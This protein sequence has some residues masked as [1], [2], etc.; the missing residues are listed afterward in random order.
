MSGFFLN[1]VQ[2][3]SIPSFRTAV[4]REWKRP[5]REK[6]QILRSE[7]Q[8]CK[9]ERDRKKSEMKSGF[10]TL[11]ITTKKITLRTCK[12]NIRKTSKLKK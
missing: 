9:I 6:T 12:K 10:E 8:E 5:E 2:D 3:P 7:K 11:A 1:N 4:G